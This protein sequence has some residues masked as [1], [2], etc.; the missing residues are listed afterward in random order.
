MAACYAAQYPSQVANLILL[1]PALN[2]PEYRVPEKKLEVPA[3][4]VIG[5]ADDVTP[6]DPVVMQAKKTFSHLRIEIVKDDHF[7]HNSFTTLDW[8]GLLTRG[9]ILEVVRE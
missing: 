1:A 5:D 2:F 8:H 6:I 4:L 7:L 3:L 9:V